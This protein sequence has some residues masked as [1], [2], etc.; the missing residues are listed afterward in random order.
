MNMEWISVEDAVPNDDNNVLTYS[1]GYASAVGYHTKKGWFYHPDDQPRS[2]NSLIDVTHWM[3][4]PQPPKEKINQSLYLN[5]Y[6]IFP[7]N[8]KL[9]W[10]QDFCC[11]RDDA[12]HGI[13]FLL[14]KFLS[15][16]RVCLRAHG[17]GIISNELGSYGCGSI[18]ME[19]KDIIPYMVKDGM[20]ETQ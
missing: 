2:D 10:S 17:Y 7:E 13:K 9:S 1:E 16:D 11:F 6:F 20:D 18:C 12:P 4:L 15:D 5:K 19:I 3:P 8:N 14:Y